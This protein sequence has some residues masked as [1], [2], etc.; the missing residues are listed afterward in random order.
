MPHPNLHTL[1]AAAK[2][3]L[4]EIDRHPDFKA[5]NYHPDLTIGDAQT[6]LTHLKSQLEENCDLNHVL[7]KR[8]RY[9]S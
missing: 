8:S 5:I 1:V 3:I 4:S 6:A 9:T 7:T 2:F